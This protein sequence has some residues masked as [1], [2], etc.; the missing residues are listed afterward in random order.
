MVNFRELVMNQMKPIPELEAPG[1]SVPL[2]TPLAAEKAKMEGVG[3]TALE[4]P[5]SGKDLSPIAGEWLGFP[6]E[7]LK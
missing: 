6:T 7:V 5:E 4:L 2:L 3:S 1:V